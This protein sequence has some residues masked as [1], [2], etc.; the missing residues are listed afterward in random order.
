MTFEVDITARSFFRDVDLN[1]LET[2]LI[3]AL[4]VEAVAEAVLSVTLTDNAD[5][6]RINREHL[7]H[8]YPTD[9]I[10]FQLEW[11]HPDRDQPEHTADGRS[12]GARIEGEIIAS[13]EYAAAEAAQQGWD[14]QSELTLYVIHG[15]LHICGYDDLEFA[16]KD[17]MRAREAAVL[18]QL[19]RPVIPRR[20]AALSTDSQQEARE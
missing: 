10:S 13:V 12:A 11:S 9:V 19:G 7:Q 5:I 4:H 8:D 20:P 18:N 17:V 1:D 6:H 16:E 3:Q 2:S 15:M 14:V